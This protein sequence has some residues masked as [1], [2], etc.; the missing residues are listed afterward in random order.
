MEAGAAL[1]WRQGDWEELG[2][3]RVSP[4]TLALIP[5]GRWWPAG[6]RLQRLSRKAGGQPSSCKV[7]REK[8]FAAQI[9]GPG[10]YK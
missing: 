4:R 6:L 8:E 10:V 7:T 1:H 5:R 3:A 9:Y 2:G